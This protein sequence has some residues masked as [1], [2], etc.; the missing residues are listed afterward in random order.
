MTKWPAQRFREKAVRAALWLAGK[1]EELTAWR[2]TSRRGLREF[3]R[4]HELHGVAERTARG[5]TYND[6]WFLFEV[7][8]RAVRNAFGRR[9]LNANYAGM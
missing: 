8:W 5:E 9:T 4:A 6:E 7:A 3:D 1:S 2:A